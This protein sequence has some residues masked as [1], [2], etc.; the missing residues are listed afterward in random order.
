MFSFECRDGWEPSIR[1]IAEKL[2]KLI[3][4]QIEKDPQGWEYGF[5]RTSQLKEKFGSG[6]WYLSAGTDE[7]LKLTDEWEEQTEHICETCGKSGKIRGRGW[8][9]ASCWKHAR[10]EDRDNLEYVEEEA[11]KRGLI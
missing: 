9:Y 10:K 7:M 11:K 6:R 2:E 3:V 1:K 4:K 5:Y 8:L